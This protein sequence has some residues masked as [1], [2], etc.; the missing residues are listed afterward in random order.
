MSLSNKSLDKEKGKNK[1][2]RR[3][4]YY[5]KSNNI[6]YIIGVEEEEGENNNQ[7]SKNKTT[8]E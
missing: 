3:I 7:V 6:A 5:I 4:N 1:I 2:L 8:K